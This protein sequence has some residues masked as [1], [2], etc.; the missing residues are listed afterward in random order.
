VTDFLGNLLEIEKA[1]E[2]LHDNAPFFKACSL[3]GLA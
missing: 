3:S 2:L 1:Q